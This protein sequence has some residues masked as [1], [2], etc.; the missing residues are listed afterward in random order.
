MILNHINL[1]VTEVAPTVAMFETYFGLRPMGLPIDDRMAFLRDDAGAVV[2]LFRV[3]DAVYPKIFHVG[4]IRE[5]VDQVIAL[6]E[7][8]TA[9]GFEP[10]TPREEHGR[11]TF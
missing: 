1:G 4:F 5:R 3:K 9:G 7:A 11:F 8:L 2:S 6:H 10:E